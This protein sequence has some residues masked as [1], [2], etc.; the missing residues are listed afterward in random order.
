MA[1]WKQTATIHQT[2]ERCKAEGL[3]VTE[4]ALRGWVKSGQLRHVKAGKKA[5]IY[6]DNLISFL[7]SGEESGGKPVLYGSITPIPERF[8][9]QRTVSK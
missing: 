2:A 3:G 9:L 8:P 5:L 6:W 4:W 1:D 7:E